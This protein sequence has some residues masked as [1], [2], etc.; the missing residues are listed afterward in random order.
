MKAQIE[1]SDRD[2]IGRPHRMVITLTPDQ[3]DDPSLIREL[4]APKKSPL[5]LDLVMQS[6]SLVPGYGISSTCVFNL[7]F[8][9]EK[10]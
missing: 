9:K 8:P 6:K 5:E 4:H 7:G 10:S 2:D 1:F 3:D